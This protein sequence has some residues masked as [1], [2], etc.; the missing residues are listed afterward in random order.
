[1]AVWWPSRRRYGRYSR[2]R[3]RRMY[4]ARSA[5]FRRFRRRRRFRTKTHIPKSLYPRSCMKRLTYYIPSHNMSQVSG[6]PGQRRYLCND[7][8]D[9]DYDT[10]LA[11]DTN[12]IGTLSSYYKNYEVIR[13]T[14]IWTF[15]SSEAN[16][17][18]MCAISKGD[19][20]TTLTVDS[21]QILDM[22]KTVRMVL[23]LHVSG[24]QFNRKV[25]KL[26]WTK[27]NDSHYSDNYSL[28]TSGPA[29]SYYFRIW[30][31]LYKDTASTGAATYGFGRIVYDVRFF[32]EH[33]VIEN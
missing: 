1:M 6:V 2:W 31:G 12:L 8:V 16:I 19:S 5:R 21:N 29:H 22:P 30:A 33:T 17:P 23:P 28:T 3:F 13:S 15:W 18:V 25:L 32:N 7:V 14:I 10:A 9:C 24:Q 11:Q 4:N 26:T 27:K 20:V